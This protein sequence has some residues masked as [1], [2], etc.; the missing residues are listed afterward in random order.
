MTGA[1]TIQYSDNFLFISAS[2]FLI[3]QLVWTGHW[4]IH[5]IIRG[6]SWELEDVE[7]DTLVSVRIIIM[8]M[9]SL[10]LEF[11]PIYICVK[12]SPSFSRKIVAVLHTGQASP[13]S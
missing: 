6:E 5:S 7:R 4:S 10:S 11:L 2:I 13:T 12:L 3:A 1:V 9:V 8:V